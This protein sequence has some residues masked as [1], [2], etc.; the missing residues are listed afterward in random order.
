MGRVSLQV[1]SLCLCRFVLCC[2]GLCY[3]MLYSVVL[4]CV[5]LCYTIDE[6]HYVLHIFK[7]CISAIL[8]TFAQPPI[9]FTAYASGAW[10]SYVVKVYPDRVTL[11]S[12]VDL[13]AVSTYYTPQVN[14][15]DRV[16]ALYASSASSISAGGFIY[17]I[18][19]SSKPTMIFYGILDAVNLRL[20]LIYSP[21]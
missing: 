5:V 1:S 8:L 2:V 18:Q 12:S 13:T 6:S 10:T 4:Y 19:F 20:S 14:T 11:A 15:T 9:H 17:Q 7:H 21:V 3:T 16:Y